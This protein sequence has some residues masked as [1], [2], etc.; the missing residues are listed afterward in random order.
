MKTDAKNVREVFINDSFLARSFCVNTCLELE[1]VPMQRTPHLEFSVKSESES[2]NRS[3][4][5]TI[6]NPTKDFANFVE[7]K[8][9]GVRATLEKFH[10]LKLGDLSTT[11]IAAYSVGEY[12][13][14]HRDNFGKEHNIVEGAG[15]KRQV[16]IVIYLNDE[17]D[18][19][20]ENTYSGGNLTFYGLTGE[21]PFADF[22]LPVKGMAGRLVAF[23]STIMHEVTKVT[24]GTRFVINTG[25][26]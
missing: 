1:S 9:S 18:E 24:R 25:F 6:L 21:G 19:Q 22:G 4:P 2:G 10:D 26:L 16:S 3:R 7:P 12:A 15:D 13:G 5:K 8:I 17:D 11:Y 20:E 14:K 23:R